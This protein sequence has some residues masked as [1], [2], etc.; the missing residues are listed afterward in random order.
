[1]SHE[2]SDIFPQVVVQV[3]G[4]A[5]EGDDDAGFGVPRGGLALTGG[6][7]LMGKCSSKLWV[8]SARRGDSS[9]ARRGDSLIAMRGRLVQVQTGADRCRPV[10]TGAVQWRQY[11]DF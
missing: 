4:S 9:S 7:G 8:R 3:G 2:R 6:Y 11:D 5:G 1:M 10:Q